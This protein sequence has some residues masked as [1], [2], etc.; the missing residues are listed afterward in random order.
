MIA[1]DMKIR[2]KIL[3]TYI[4]IIFIP[5]SVLLLSV[6]IIETNDLPLPGLQD[7]SNLRDQ[8]DEITESMRERLLASPDGPIDS[9]IALPPIFDRLFV[10]SA[11]NTILY[12][13]NDKLTGLSYDYLSINS[14]SLDAMI[15]PLNDG[16]RFLGRVVLVPKLNFQQAI[17]F[18]TIIPILLLLLFVF[19]IVATGLLLYKFLTESI[20]TPLTELNNAATRIAEGD[21]SFEMGCQHTDEIGLF[22]RTFDDMRQ[23]LK[24]SLAIQRDNEQRRRQLL[25][26][27][28]HD[29]KTPLTSIVGYVEGIQ[30]GIY[31]DEETVLNVLDMIHKKG[32][33]LSMLIDDLFVFSKLDA[34][35]FQLNR[36]TYGSSVL[37]GE[38]LNGIL[39]DFESEKIHFEI[40]DRVS[41]TLDVDRQR[42]HQIL[43][44]VLHNA[45]KFTTDTI[46]VETTI[47][48]GKYII[49]IRD[50]GRGIAP[51][52]LPRIFDFFYK[53][54]KSRGENLEGSG[55]G[56][57]I[58]KQLMVA[59]GGDITATSTP[60]EG[61]TFILSFPLQ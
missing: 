48:Q 18:L 28:T 4:S 43:T 23:Q 15:Y 57:A 11:D 55:I 42:F 17:N 40:T 34:D 59:H 3:L 58:C 26:A 5:L 29:L 7:Y 32:V 37:L 41:T 45:V 36:D 20:I 22:C 54:D 30:D 27:I 16:E 61:S 14:S 24:T 19:S 2:S 21:L 35:G 31:R 60:G 10:V 56:L 53:A 12:D 52:D 38:V 47:S 49:S 13:S 8:A 50:N 46:W 6:I 1:M 51:E 9:D 25:A 39:Y 33:N 44:N